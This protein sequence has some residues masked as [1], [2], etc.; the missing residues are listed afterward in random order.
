MYVHKV[1]TS[2]RHLDPDARMETFFES[3]GLADLMTTCYGGRNR[4]LGEAFVTT[5]PRKTLAELERD[6]LNGQKLQGPMTAAE[7][8]AKL[9]T[10][11]IAD[12]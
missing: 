1:T 9:D 6:L 5:T 2:D 12:R 7:V 8:A 10:D 3:C 4:K 11:G